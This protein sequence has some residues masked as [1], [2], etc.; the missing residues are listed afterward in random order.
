[1][2]N[3]AD[4]FATLDGIRAVAALLVVTIH[5][6]KLF[7]W[8]PTHS[9][10]YLA[11]DLFFCLSGFVLARTYRE[12]L[13]MG[14][15]TPRRFLIGRAMRFYPLYAIGTL[16]GTARL[17]IELH[18]HNVP[19]VMETAA[20]I[21]ALPGFLYLPSPLYPLPF[22][23]DWPAWSLAAELVVNAIYARLICGHHNKRFALVWLASFVSLALYAHCAG[24]LDGGWKWATLPVGIARACLSFLIGALMERCVQRERWSSNIAALL[25]VL[26]VP[27]LLMTAPALP[28]AAVCVAFPVLVFI[29]AHIEPSGV[30]RTIFLLGGRLSYGIYIIHAP[31]AN[32]Y[33]DAPFARRH[34]ELAAI[35]FVTS[36]AALVWLLEQYYV[37][38]VRKFIASLHAAP[39]S[40]DVIAQPLQ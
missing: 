27:V 29:A 35:V 14:T 10:L 30:T 11:V 23:L 21:T 24:D 34:A 15:L 32:L 12:R 40:R 37:P 28:L 8:L 6:P 17:V 16:V 7:P 5:A 26:A 33:Q 38:R 31:L 13:R 2:S 19:P 39:I 22:P 25:S 20:V 9:G 4:R 18:S 36:V 1:M 3:A